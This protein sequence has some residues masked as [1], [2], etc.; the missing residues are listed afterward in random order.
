VLDEDRLWFYQLQDY[1]G[2]PYSYIYLSPQL[3]VKEESG[4]VI[5]L[6]NSSSPAVPTKKYAEINVLYLCI[7]LM[8]HCSYNCLAVKLLAIYLLFD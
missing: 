8:L 5:T 7:Y 3:T 2:G 1:A 6:R 4:Y